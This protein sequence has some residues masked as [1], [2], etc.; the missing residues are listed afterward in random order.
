M[1][2][3]SKKGLIFLAEALK[4]VQLETHIQYFEDACQTT[5]FCYVDVL[6]E[7]IYRFLMIDLHNRYQSSQGV[8]LM[9]NNIYPS[10]ELEPCKTTG[11]FGIRLP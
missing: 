11:I 6:I 1:F 3:I 10:N 5:S 2:I 9:R 4:I 7:S 8:D